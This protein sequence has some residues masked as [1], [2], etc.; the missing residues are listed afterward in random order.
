ML[1][2]F[3]WLKLLALTLVLTV[4]ASY[5]LYN[6]DWFQRKFLY[7]FPHRETV[8]RYAL[9]RS[10]DPHLVAGM[11]R[12]ESKFIPTARSPKGAVGLMQIMP[13]TGYWVAEQL[14]TAN[15]TEAML[16]DPELSI[17][18]GTWY[19]ASLKK[20]FRDNEILALAAYNGGQGNV[21]QWMRQYGW[22]ADFRDVD[23]IPFPETREYVKRVLRAKDKYR[24]L[25]G[26]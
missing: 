9:E 13:E 16:T 23:K 25:Y 15:F 26:R 21:R 4:A 1:R 12:T 14:N 18:F 3:T 8:Y 11:I 17:R 6:S 2:I 24:D 22:T 20:D 10:L 19:M 5:F 7:P